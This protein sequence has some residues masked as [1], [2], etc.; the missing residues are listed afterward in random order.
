M[1]VPVEHGVMPSPMKR[2]EERGGMRYVRN[3]KCRRSLRTSDRTEGRRHGRPGLLNVEYPG[4]K[5]G[6]P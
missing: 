5:K 2:P 1:A 3:R 6:E 4:T